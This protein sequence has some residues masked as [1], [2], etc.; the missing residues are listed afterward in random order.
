MC[1]DATI[2]S[3]AGTRYVDGKFHALYGKEDQII[4]ISYSL[5]SKSFLIVVDNK[6]EY[7]MEVEIDGASHGADTLHYTGADIVWNDS[8]GIFWWRYVLTTAMTI[9][10]I[11]LIN[12]AN[13]IPITS[14]IL[15]TI[16]VLI[17]FRIIF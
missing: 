1:P 15:Y 2:L 12:R 7:K 13:R 10:S 4:D 6:D 3:Y 11:V 16:S 8:C 5:F 14:C 17:S 9:L